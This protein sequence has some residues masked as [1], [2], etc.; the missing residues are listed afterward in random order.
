MKDIDWCAFDRKAEAVEFVQTEIEA[1]LLTTPYTRLPPHQRKAAYLRD[2]RPTLLRVAR[3]LGVEYTCVLRWA[4]SPQ[5]VVAPNEPTACR[6]LRRHEACRAYW[7]CRNSGLT[8]AKLERDAPALVTLRKLLDTPTATSPFECVLRSIRRSVNRRFNAE[9]TLGRAEWT[10]V[11]LDGA[12]SH[13][14]AASA[15]LA[16]RIVDGWLC[17]HESDVARAGR[18]ECGVAER[19][20]WRHA[21]QVRLGRQRRRGGRSSQR[22]FKNN[23]SADIR[24]QPLRFSA[25]ERLRCQSPLAAAI[26]SERAPDRPPIAAGAMLV[27]PSLSPR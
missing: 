1:S 25:F 5:R 2:A 15:A 7:V 4:R 26:I 3:S 10:S 24:C 22:G 18:H 27:S 14:S 19:R 20:R 9:T 21:D 16:K 12:L 13:V 11:T 6:K 17:Y 23:S 8:V